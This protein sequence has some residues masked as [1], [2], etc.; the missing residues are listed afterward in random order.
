MEGAA[1]KRWPLMLGALGLLFLSLGRAVPPPSPGGFAVGHF[2][3]IAEIVSADSKET[4]E[5]ATI[6]QVGHELENTAKFFEQSGWRFRAEE[7]RK[8]VAANRVGVAVLGMSFA[9]LTYEEALA[10][11]PKQSEIEVKCEGY[12]SRV[13]RLSDLKLGEMERTDKRDSRILLVKIAL[14]KATEAKGKNEDE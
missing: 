4:I 3:L 13:V 1:M 10:F 12:K 7:I 8:P 5:G 14:E 9:R 11:D 6:R 2:T